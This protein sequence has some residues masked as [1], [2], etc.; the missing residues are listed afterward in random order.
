MVIK[1]EVPLFPSQGKPLV[2]SS[3]ALIMK[4]VSHLHQILNYATEPSAMQN[5]DTLQI[6]M[7]VSKQ[8]M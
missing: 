1:S 6:L 5:P 4:S 3:F 2:R 7:K 8:N